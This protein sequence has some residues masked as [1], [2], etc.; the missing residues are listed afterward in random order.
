MSGFRVTV[1]A[2]VANLGPGFDAF[3]MAVDLANEVVVEM[4]GSPGVEVHGE[5][6]GELAGDGSNLILQTMTFLARELGGTVPDVRLVCRNRI[7]LQRGLGSSS[8]AIVAGL[9]IADRLLDARFPPERLLE[10]A[11][12]LE[13]HADNVG[14]ALFGGLRISYLSKGGWRAAAL[15]PHHDLRPVLLIP[16]DERLRTEDARRAL[17]VQVPRADA[18]FN[19]A[20]AGLLTLALTSRPELLRDALEDRL[21]QQARLPLVPA[22]RAVFEDLR[23]REV[24]VCVAGAGPSLLAFEEPGREIGSPGPSWRVHRARIAEGASIS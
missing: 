12:D 16:L 21:H 19:L 1:P 17:P 14:P 10:V 8:A 22:A 18:N 3:G 24:P 5:G 15:E 7:P 6:E 2:T 4:E 11:A 13:G 20:R 9:L 23:E